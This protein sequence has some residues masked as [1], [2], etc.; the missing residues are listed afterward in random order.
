MVLALAVVVGV[1]V[2]AAF[3]GRLGRLADLELRGRK[4]FAAAIALQL[5]AYPSGVLP[6]TI[7]D[8]IATGLWLATY[9]VLIVCAVLNRSVPGFPLATLGLA[10]HLRPGGVFALWSN[11]PPDGEF[12][13]VLREVFATAQ[14]HVVAFPNPLRDRDETNTVYVARA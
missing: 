4:L 2:G 3:G 14:A 6:W 13:A 11:D 10:S 7:S 8:R 9:G 1:L 12:E 5:A